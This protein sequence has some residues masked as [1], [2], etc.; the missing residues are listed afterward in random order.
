[1]L[2]FDPN[3]MNQPHDW[4][5]TDV[6]WVALNPEAYEVLDGVVWTDVTFVN[7]KIKYEGMAP[8]ELHKVRFVNCTFEIATGQKGTMLAEY[9]A[10]SW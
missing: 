7:A 3:L 4:K 1:M 10:L 5:V 2:I 6:T 9:V 8:F